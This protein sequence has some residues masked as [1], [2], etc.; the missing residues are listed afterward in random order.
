M[1][2]TAR[3]ATTSVALRRE[4]WIYGTTGMVMFSVSLPATRMAVLAFDP[5]FV[6]F[7]R[8]AGAGTLALLLLIVSRHRMPGRGD[9]VSLVAI[10]A[11]VVFGFPLL[12]AVAL[13]G[14]T[15]AHALIYLGLLPLS[16]ACFGVLR[17][18]DRPSELFWL[19]ACMGAAIVV[20]YACTLGAASGSSLSDI[21][22]TAAIV[23]CGAGYAEGGRLSR[24]LGGWQ[25]ISWA[26]VLSLPISVPLAWHFA[27]GGA[28]VGD[29][30]G[31]AGLAYVTLIS[32][33]VG[34][35]FWYRGLALSG[36][37]AVGQLQLLQPFL[38]LLWAGLLLSERIDPWIVAACAGVVACVAG[39]KRFESKQVNDGT[40][41]PLN[42]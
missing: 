25:V 38:G 5:M 19:F 32:Q 17:A 36:V 41:E 15:S 37:A 24:T 21:A 2:A 3:P 11:G 28:A 20:A 26:L 22:M 31:I 4:G 34:F 18:G 29:R 33:F 10:A 12:T 8:A 39:A 40:C 7:A 1:S 16:T 35:I 6:T 9:L 13:R 14:T 42:T 30:R 27:P 23:V